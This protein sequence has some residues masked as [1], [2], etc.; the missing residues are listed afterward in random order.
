MSNNIAGI[1]TYNPDFKRLQENIQAIITQIDELIIV[2]NNSDNIA[3]FE[4]YIKKFPKIKIIKNKENLGIATALN[5]LCGYA[6]KNEYSWILTLDQDSVC[7][8]EIIKHYNEFINSSNSDS[9]IGILTCYIEDRNFV[10]ED[11][12]IDEGKLGFSY[13]D[14]CI[15][16]GSYINLQIWNKIGGFDEK[17]FIDKVDTDYCQTMIEN[18]LFIVKINYVGLLHEVGSNTRIVKVFHKKIHVFN[19]SPFRCYY[20]A[21]NSIYF[22]RKHKDYIDFWANYKTA[23]HRLLVVLIF[24]KQKSEKIRQCIRG[25]ID[26]HKLSSSS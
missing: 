9:N 18:N 12:Y 1:V 16:S 11:R 7:F 25:I 5:Q 24:E 15:T 4:S 3:I 26:G 23:Y 22:A 21:R 2:D 20:I 19:H 17:Y 6:E 14:F 10:Y 8:P 13:T